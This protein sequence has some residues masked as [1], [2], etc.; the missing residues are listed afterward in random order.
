MTE[1]TPVGK[2]NKNILTSTPSPND[3]S[4]KL[5]WSSE[6]SSIK[7]SI[8]DKQA[9]RFIKYI[10]Q[11]DIENDSSTLHPSSTDSPQDDNNF[12]QHHYGS[13]DSDQSEASGTSY[14]FDRQIII[15]RKYNENK[16]K[17]KRRY[18]GMSTCLPDDFDQQQQKHHQESHEGDKNSE[19]LVTNHISD[20]EITLNKESNKRKYKKIR[21][22][23][24]PRREISPPKNIPECLSPI[25]VY[26][27]IK[28][29]LMFEK[30]NALKNK[31]KKSLIKHKKKETKFNKKL[32][33][34]G[35][36]GFLSKNG[37]YREPISEIALNKVIK[38]Y[39]GRYKNSGQRQKRLNLKKKNEILKKKIREAY[40][41]SDDSASELFDAF[42]E[43]N[44]N[45]FHQ[46]K[47]NTRQV[48]LKTAD[49][50]NTTELSEASQSDEETNEASEASNVSLDSSKNRVT[51][52][53][54]TQSDAGTLNS[55]TGISTS[56]K[57]QSSSPDPS[58]SLSQVDEMTT[59]HQHQIIQH[60]KSESCVDKS[61]NHHSKSLPT[62]RSVAIVNMIL[63]NFKKQQASTN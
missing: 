27:K 15:T 22:V 61:E 13:G 45:Y 40:D 52:S 4:H 19:T 54:T 33:G 1:Y 51:S 8:S 29:D 18:V 21:R 26:H 16:S 25:N 57:E 10:R 41:G 31:N 62:I 63:H 46:E 50:N 9:A 47:K 55:S 23:S 39:Q 42:V 49:S 28:I 14:S 11:E 7:K 48:I 30:I 60:E 35:L 6:L 24:S 43:K 32:S 38:E 3:L 53:N 44:P 37:L 34:N 20:D 59:S 36:L 2:N 5:S 12:K 58:Q 56:R 17:R